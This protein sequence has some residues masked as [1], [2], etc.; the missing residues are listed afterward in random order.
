M[1]PETQSST[2]SSLTTTTQRVTS[3]SSSSSSSSLYYPNL[4]TKFDPQMMMMRY[5]KPRLPPRLN[6]KHFDSLT[7]TTT[8]TTTTSSTSSSI[9]K[10][11]KFSHLYHHT[12]L[13]EK[14]LDSRNDANLTRLISHSLNMTRHAQSQIKNQTLYELALSMYENEH[15]QN[16]IKN[17]FVISNDNSFGHFILNKLK[18]ILFMCMDV[19]VI[20]MRYYPLMG[21]MDGDGNNERR[22]SFVCMLMASMYMW[23]D[24]VYNVLLTGVCEGKLS[25]ILLHK[26]KM[27]I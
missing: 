3:S 2:K 16:V 4:M 15:V 26:K 5:S 20:G 12:N 7:T 22:N 27:Y 1:E 9:T 11:K 24:I 13:K 6:W 8:T 10:N 21:V 25:F 18:V 19:F 17:L 23:A 14:L